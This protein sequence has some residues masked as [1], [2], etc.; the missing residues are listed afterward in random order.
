MSICLKN[1]KAV[2]RVEFVPANFAS[3]L[4]A[5][6][7]AL[8]PHPNQ[9]LN[10]ALPIFIALAII[11]FISIAGAHLNTYSDQMLDRTDSTKV[12]LVRATSSMGQG[13]LKILILFEIALSVPF[14]AALIF[15]R[16]TPFLIFNYALAIFFAYAYSMPP[17]RFK[18]RSLLAMV[19]LMLVL[20]ILPIT[21]VYFTVA[22]SPEP[23]F[24]SFLAGQCMTIYGLII[25][26]EIRDHATDKAGRI[27]TMTVW[28]GLERA[29]LFGIALLVTGSLLMSISLILE[30]SSLGLPILSIAIVAPLLAVAYVIH[31]YSILR[32][33]SKMLSHDSGAGK[34]LVELSAQNPKWITLI[35]QTIV[36]SSFVLLIAKLLV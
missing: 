26:T 21:F 33:L 36:L 18:A 25:P 13:R 27:K 1:W 29:A 6:A 16:P 4:I 30:F 35:S 15:V 34:R 19:S 8:Q 17:L 22:S 10:L 24:I 31:K 28:L 7:W 9:P 2:S 32:A 14:V 23:R 5:L 11:C 12:E 20:S 3:L